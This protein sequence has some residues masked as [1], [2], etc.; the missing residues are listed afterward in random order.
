MRAYVNELALAEACATAS[1]QHKPL[2]ELLKARHHH[3]ALVRALFCARAMPQVEV[4][5][6]LSLRDLGHQLPKESRNS[7][8][9]WTDRQGPFIDDDRQAADPDTFWFGDDEVTNGGLGEAARRRLSN[10]PAVVLSPVYESTSRFAE[11]AL[12]IIQGLLPDEAIERVQVQNYLHADQL[13]EDIAAAEPEPTNWPDSLTLARRRF[14]RLWIGTH[15]DSSL[16]RHTFRPSQSRR[17][18]ELFRVLQEVMQA[19]DAGGDLSGKGKRLIQKHFVGQ[20]AWFTDESDTRKQSPANFTFP[21]PA[22]GAN[23]ICFWHGKISHQGFRMYF[24]WP[25]A[26]PTERLRVV[27]I[28]PHL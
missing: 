21:D 20:R 6:G 23:L 12:A 18:F 10:Q 19:M 26:M 9:I 1:P 5:D 7:L 24:E 25:P 4:R 28:G 22:G 3:K 27:Y 13:A 8:F 11:D 14:D 17:M 16:S 15:C 2:L